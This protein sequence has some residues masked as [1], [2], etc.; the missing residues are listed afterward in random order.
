[1]SIAVDAPRLFMKLRR[2]VLRNQNG[3]P[4]IYRGNC[5]VGQKGGR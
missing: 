1:M 2:R 5:G 3:Q 4:L